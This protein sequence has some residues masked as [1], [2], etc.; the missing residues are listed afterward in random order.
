LE[1]AMT[2]F[3]EVLELC[4]VVDYEKFS[5]S[6]LFY[7]AFLQAQL[8]KSSSAL[9]IANQLYDD[10]PQEQLPFWVT[11]Y[12]LSYLGQTYIKLGEPEKAFRVFDR[13]LECV[14]AS[15]YTQASIKAQNGR[16]ALYRQKGD[17]LTAQDCHEEAIQMAKEMGAQYD[18]AEAYY[19]RGLTYQTASQLDEANISFEQAI[20]IF[21]KIHAPRQIA[22][23]KNA[24]ELDGDRQR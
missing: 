23:V 8:G 11:E 18:L 12:R 10:I 13:V 14:K 3:L 22:R 16:A 19:Q 7:V 17:F 4:R 24:R 20:Q 6:V 9:A 2:N 21:E 5:P 15:P 1:T